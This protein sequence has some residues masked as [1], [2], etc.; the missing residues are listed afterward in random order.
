MVRECAADQEGAKAGQRTTV[1]S[2]LTELRRRRMAACGQIDVAH[3]ARSL[4]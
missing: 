4:H 1:G 3:A 2:R